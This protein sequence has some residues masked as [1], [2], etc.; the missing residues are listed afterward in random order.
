MARKL[1][2]ALL[3]FVPFALLVAG[4]GKAPVA[5]VN[6]QAITQEQVADILMKDPQ[7]KQAV[8]ELIIEQLLDA[9]AK[10]LKV[11]VTPEEVDTELADA[12]ES[13]GGME[14]FLEMVK[15]RGLSEEDLKKTI[16]NNLLWE[17]IA[18]N[19]VKLT[20]AD[21]KKW[22][23]TNR[24]FLDEPAKADISI[25]VTRSKKEADSVLAKLKQGADFATTAQ[26][27]S[28]DPSA[29]QGGALGSQSLYQLP[30]EIAKAVMKMS[31][32]SL[33]QVIEVKPQYGGAAEGSTSFY[34]VQ[35]R[36]MTPEKKAS[37]DDPKTKEKVTRMAKREKGM[38]DV[39]PQEYLSKGAKITIVDE[40]FK[41]LEAQFQS[42]ELLGDDAEKAPEGAPAPTPAPAPAPAPAPTNGG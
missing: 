16:R 18:T 19:D 2:I 13:A 22:F 1:C 5:M 40:R 20:D 14:Q 35:L 7:A 29:K 3:I 12:A 6:G 21:V 8:A 30:P 33:S 37:L 34:I 25:I 26:Q 4:C 41:E 10:E 23:E 15:S 11:T 24:M 38:A 27:S 17:K 9:K 31:P 28:E 32:G 36:S 42:K 39:N